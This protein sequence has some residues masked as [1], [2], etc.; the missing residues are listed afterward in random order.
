MKAID[1]KVNEDDEWFE[2]LDEVF[3]FKHIIHNWLKDVEL[4][5]MVNQVS[6]REISKKDSK[7]GIS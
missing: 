7:A 4:G 6:S 3:S 5:R 1:D 2:Q